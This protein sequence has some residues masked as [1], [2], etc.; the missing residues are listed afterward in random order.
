MLRNV[1]GRLRTNLISARCL[2]ATTIFSTPPKPDASVSSKRLDAIRNIG[3][4]AHIDAGKTTTTERMLFYSGKTRRVGEVDRG[5]TVMDYLPQERE[6]GITIR[7]AATTFSWRVSDR[8]ADRGGTINLIDTPGHVDFTFEVDSALWA[9]DGAVTILDGSAGVEAQTQTVW[10]QASKYKIPRIVFVNKLDKPGGDFARCLLELGDRLKC[11]PLPVIEPLYDAGREKLL[12]V[13]DIIK[14]RKIIFSGPN[15]EAVSEEPHACSPKRRALLEQM[16]ELDEDFLEKYLENQELPDES[17]YKCLER[18]TAS[19]KCVPV[20]AGSSFHNIGVQPLMD[21]IFRYLPG[22]DLR[23]AS[24]APILRALA[25]KVVVDEQRGILVYLRVCTG[26]V[27]HGK[28][29]YNVSGGKTHKERVQKVMQAS[30]KDLVEVAE[31]GPGSIVVV[32]GLKS[33]ATGD[34]LSEVADDQE[35][36]QL[37]VPAPVFQVACWAPSRLEEEK[38]V[39]AL[40]QMCLEDPSLKLAKDQ[41]TGQWLLAGQGELHLEVAGHRLRREQRQESVEFGKVRIALRETVVEMVRGELQYDRQLDD[42]RLSGLLSLVLEP[43]PLEEGLYVRDRV[44]ID[45]D[46]AGFRLPRHLSP[47]EYREAVS[48]GVMAG[49]TN[50][51]VR[52]SRLCGLRVV[53]KKLH[54]LDSHSTTTAFKHCAIQ[55]LQNLGKVFASKFALAEPVMSLAVRLDPKDLGTVLPDLHSQ[56]RATVFG[57]GPAPDDPQV[58]VIEAEAPLPL[59]VGYVSW[60]RTA[61]SGK[62]SLEMQVKGYRVCQVRPHQ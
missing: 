62:A 55:L 10:R 41:Q 22:P 39:T 57:Y 33:T 49:L 9:M 35:L 13:L 21:A 45:F 43:L 15:G 23:T 19:S 18:L 60:L 36:G 34:T 50:G 24:S 4:I 28:T 37:E 58:Q 51:P 6:R 32:T 8:E 48:D 17:I 26:S 61:T 29:L 53:V 3:I 47:Q 38:M 27:T 40:E 7:A 2:A 46:S 1:P 12:G 56:R 5:D 11:L 20:L 42:L 25:F 44:E 52:G 14:Q 30:G 31:A 16:A 59:L 54:Y